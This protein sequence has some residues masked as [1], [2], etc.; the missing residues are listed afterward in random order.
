MNQVAIGTFLVEHEVP[1]LLRDVEQKGVTCD[2]EQRGQGNDRQ[3]I[4]AQFDL[5]VL[6]DAN[7]IMIS[8]KL[9]VVIQEVSHCLL[10]ACKNLFVLF[11]CIDIKHGP[12]T[13]SVSQ[14]IITFVHLT[15]SGIVS[16]FEAAVRSCQVSEE[17]GPGAGDVYIVH[18]CIA[19]A[20]RAW[21]PV[22]NLAIFA[23]DRK[24]SRRRSYGF[25]DLA[26]LRD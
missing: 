16:V 24:G 22:T 9:Q 11:E 23:W 14:N 21:R 25:Q 8:E 12:D 1:K 7:T 4:T 2:L 26:A 6:T 3:S 5:I 17:P 18:V 10:G 15:G 19:C 20:M 13:S